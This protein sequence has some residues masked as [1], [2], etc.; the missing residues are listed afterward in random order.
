MGQ[1]TR[2][3]FIG[4]QVL[5]DTIY[6]WSIKMKSMKL[7]LENWDRYIEQEEEQVNVEDILDHGQFDKIANFGIVDKLKKSGV[8]KNRMTPT[9]IQ[10]ISNLIV[11]IPPEVAMVLLAHIPVAGDTGPANLMDIYKTTADNGM[12]VKDYIISIL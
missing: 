8:L 4:N 12:L 3:S 1:T 2:S 5:G 11:R 9:Q 7:V 6:S 10:N